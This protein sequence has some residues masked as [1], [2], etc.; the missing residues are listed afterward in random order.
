MSVHANDVGIDAERDRVTALTRRG[1]GLPAAGMLYWIA[2]AV[3]V[4][5]L[6]QNTALVYSF[7]LTG[8]VFPVGILLTRLAGGDLFAKSEKL[9]SL[10]LILAAIQLFYWPIL[11]VVF[12]HAT[13]WTPFCM[14][15]LFGSH[16]LPYAWLYKSRGYAVMAILTSVTLIAAALI[17]QSS[18]YLWAPPIAAA[19]YAV[20]VTMVVRENAAI[21]PAAT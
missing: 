12:R 1:I 19:C 11:M 7:V 14:A 15:V 4:R 17:T 20:A 5:T 8:M 6:P 9:T 21:R 13:P 2:V 18:L 3:L 10:G 16:F